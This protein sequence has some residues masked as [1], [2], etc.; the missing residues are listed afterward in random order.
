MPPLSRP[1]SVQIEFT[2]GCSRRCACCGINSIREKA[3][4][5]L[6]FIETELLGKIAE[7]LGKYAPTARVEIAMHGEPLLHPRHLDLVQILRRNLPKTQI[8][9]TTNGRA[10]M[11]RMQKHLDAL[12]EVGLDFVILDTYEPERNA[13]REEAR[14]L[15]GIRVRDFYKECISDGWTPY[16]NHGRKVS[17]T[18]ILMDDLL[19]MDGVAKCRVIFNHAGNGKMGRKLRDPL[20]AT[21]TNPF[22][23]IAVAYDGDVNICCMDFGHEYV[24]G[25]AREESLQAIWEGDAFEAARMMLQNKRRDFSPCGRCD[26]PSGPRSGLLPK[27]PPV[28]GACVGTIRR[29]VE[30]S[31]ARKRNKL[32]VM[33]PCQR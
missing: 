2:E 11:G 25:N 12:Y 10:L 7:D 32:E 29:M 28:D 13:L 22:R 16:S 18:V 5:G 31:L 30:R 3:G 24:A 6:C 17:K 15:T 21:C 33:Y 27:Y 26:H 20:Q 23:E 9:M 8:Q 14:T 1:W 19:A 4:E